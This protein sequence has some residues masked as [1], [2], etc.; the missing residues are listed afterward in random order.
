MSIAP[1]L[2]T[3]LLLLALSAAGGC[4]REAAADAP[5]TVGGDAVL[6]SVHWG[7]LADIYSLDTSTGIEVPQLWRRD[8]L[9]G[10]DVA[11]DVDDRWRFLPGDAATLQPRLWIKAAADS[12]DFAVAVAAVQRQV[13]LLT[14]A[15]FDAV[16]TVFDV[17]PR[18]AALRLQFD[19]QL[20]IDDAFFASADG[21]AERVHN[22]DAVQLL[23]IVGKG[24][25]GSALLQPLPVRIAV[26]GDAIVVD[27]VLL[28][29]EALAW[30]SP[31]NASGM[32]ASPDQN[33]AN[34]RLAIA[35]TGPLALPGVT[36]K[37]EAALGNDNRGQPAIVRDFRSGNRGDQS[38]DLMHGFVRD[39]LPLHLLGDLPLRLESARAIDA[40]TIEVVLFKDGIAHDIDQGD[41]LVAPP[42]LSG[43][44][45]VISEVLVDPD[46]DRGDGSVDHVRVRVRNVPGLLQLAP[47]GTPPAVG[48][49]EW[50][51]QHARL[52]S[53]RC[54]FDAGHGDDARW[55]VRFEPSTAPGNAAPVVPGTDVSPFAGVVLRFDK[56]VDLDSVR[57]LDT[58]FFAT[59][60]L[61]SL[62]GI[63]EFR[64]QRG[65]AAGLFDEAK[66]RTP[67]LVGA[68]AG[69]A[70]GTQTLVRLQTLLGFYLDDAMRDAAA[71]G[72]PWRYYLHLVAGGI[73]IH[74]LAGQQLDLG[75]Q[76]RQLVLPFTVDARRIQGQPTQPDNRV[77]YCARRFAGRDED[78]QPSYDRPAEIAAATSMA[79]FALADLFGAHQLLEGRLLGR[80]TSRV[81]VVADDTSQ[82]QPPPETAITRWC[83]VGTTASSTVG[84][85]YTAGGIQNPMNPYGSHLQTVWREVDLS[86]SRVDANDMDLDV[87]AMWWAPFRGRGV[88]FDEFDH[89]SLHLGHAERRPEPCADPLLLPAWPESGLG[90]DFQRNY[91]FNP[92]IEG[93]FKESGPDRHAAYVDQPM[94]IDPAAVVLAPGGNRYLPLPP[95]RQPYFTWRDQTVMQ[96]GG[97][98]GSNGV[99]SDT[100]QNRSHQPYIPSPF[101]AGRGDATP[102]GLG[103][104]I[105]GQWNNFHNLQM[106]NRNAQDRATGGLLG[107]IA[108]PLLADFETA[109]DQASLPAGNGYVAFGT[110]GWQVS[111]TLTTGATPNFRVYSGGKPD[112]CV[113]SGMTEWGLATGGFK[114]D[115]TPTIPG[116]NTL[117]WI[118]LELQKRSTVSTAGFIDLHNPHRMLTTS[119][120]PRLGPYAMGSEAP[121]FQYLLDP[122]ASRQPAGTSV[123]PQF[124][125]AGAVDPQPWTFAEEVPPLNFARP[126]ADNVPL[127]PYKA[128]DAHIRKY[129]DRSGRACWTH[130]YQRVVTDYVQDPNTL[131]TPA[132]T[133]QYV[134][135]GQPFTPP[136]I[137]YVNW[138]LLMSNATELNP[139]VSP[140][141]DSFILA[142]RLPPQ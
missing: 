39:P 37:R 50:L 23:Q 25:D 107:S 72:A 46:A 65:L 11:D 19:R 61:L 74:D 40:Q 84:T 68:L 97:E 69:D 29:P 5:A 104:E 109:C 27:P 114:L 88:E 121:E 129:D 115:G 8:Q 15:R 77:V 62:D 41:S 45:P 86:L 82:L 10:V 106:Q 59:R 131:F 137:R 22:Q 76:V 117:Y 31:S 21:G 80:P 128:C 100:R 138:R 78:E 113:A 95:L 142:W 73:G 57:P 98:I 112:H 38:A 20:G 94:T 49:D 132:F 71:N 60:D 105:R 79:E 102:Q 139:P 4:H 64:S 35:L 133:A 127:D 30:L 135:P 63:D 32:P 91:L 70:D 124:R 3:C 55:F 67:Y 96:Q 7:R 120:D 14:P 119:T 83:P 125:A 43:G 136:D 44:E 66:F 126:D 123:V 34:L 52:L 2:R 28:G 58:L 75:G 56:P 12:P 42:P 13:R 9:L 24:T 17:V 90:L 118:M 101:R 53:L 47:A 93:N 116:D 54:A 51:R 141:I 1:V 111:L 99:P 134:Q 89:C 103:P 130:Y 92:T 85:V 108:L 36:G 16:R 6:T 140:A 110:N 26:Q 18:N 87:E 33:G 122:P 48:R 81:R